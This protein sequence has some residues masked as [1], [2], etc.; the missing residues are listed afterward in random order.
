MSNGIARFWLGLAGVFLSYLFV[1]S[2]IFFPAANAQ[3]TSTYGP[4]YLAGYLFGAEN[5]PYLIGCS[6]V[7]GL[8]LLGRVVFVGPINREVGR[9]SFFWSVAIVTVWSM[10]FF[11]FE[12][13]GSLKKFPWYVLIIPAWL[14][15]LGIEKFAGKDELGEDHQTGE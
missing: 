14:F 15:G 5:A 4:A 1:Q 9:V 3:T 10:A 7:W 6:L 2:L 11:V 12:N 13:F 8:A